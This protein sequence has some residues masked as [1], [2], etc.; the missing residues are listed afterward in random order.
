MAIS[1]A[2]KDLLAAGIWASAPTANRTEPEIL[3][4]ERARGWPLAYEQQDTGK[5]P[6]REVFNQRDFELD[7]AIR[8]CVHYGVLP[9]DP[10]ID[11]PHDETA[12][13]FVTTVT[14]LW[15]NT[16]PTGPSFGN[17]TDPDAS[18]QTVWERY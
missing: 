6:E 5:V 2:T 17:S 7:S 14:G 1:Q 13:A 11:Y 3:G 15:R 4:L 16:E 10:D 8:D 18:G 9:W 12:S